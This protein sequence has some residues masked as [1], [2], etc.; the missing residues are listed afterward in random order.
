MA[1]IFV[2]AYRPLTSH[3]PTASEEIE[4]YAVYSALLEELFVKDDVRLLAIQKQTIS[5]ADSYFIQVIVE[6]PIS[7]MKGYFPSVREDTLLDYRAKNQRPST[8]SAEL[9]L[10]VEY[11]IIDEVELKDK[12]GAWID[13]HK[14]YTD[15]RGVI[16]LSKVGFNKE[17]TEAFVYVEY[18]GPFVL[19]G[20][21]KNILLERNSGVWRVKGQFV[22]WQS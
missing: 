11:A 13:Y 10:P 8:L 4:G 20:F 14:R 5:A 12:D 6:T 19:G 22:G 3:S 15:A 16:R 17:R 18:T 7:D 1:A 2:F 9:N 21:G